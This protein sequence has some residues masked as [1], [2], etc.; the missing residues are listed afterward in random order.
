MA[1]KLA[2]IA[3]GKEFEKYL[4]QEFHV[5][6]KEL[7][8]LETEK[9]FTFLQLI[10]PMGYIPSPTVEWMNNQNTQ[11]KISIKLSKRPNTEVITTVLAEITSLSDPNSNPQHDRSYKT[12]V[13]QLTQWVWDTIQ[14]QRVQCFNTTPEGKALA[15]A[16][17]R[18]KHT[19]DNAHAEFKQ[20]P[21]PRIYPEVS[22]ENRLCARW[23]DDLQ[24]KLLKHARLFNFSEFNIVMPTNQQ[25]DITMWLKETRHTCGELMRILTHADM[26]L[27]ESLADWRKHYAKIP[28][29]EEGDEGVENDAN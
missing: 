14:T 13:R 18:L 17:Q 28:C 19:L 26:E 3:R 25:I 11:F 15:D 4:T 20:R 2:Y 23:T 21:D 22:I 10:W 16:S 6:L 12:F 24:S 1:S 8:T 5:S 27:S 7:L 9:L 29:I